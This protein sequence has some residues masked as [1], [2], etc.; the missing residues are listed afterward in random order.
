[1]KLVEGFD[2]N[3]RYVLVAARR[4]RQLQN[5]AQPV[6]QSSF[7]E[8]LPHRRRRDPGRQG[9]VDCARTA[10]DP[11]GSGY[12][13]AGRRDW[14]RSRRLTTDSKFATR[15]WLDGTEVLGLSS[16]RS[17]LI[18]HPGV[19]A[20]PPVAPSR[21]FHFVI[22]SAARDLLFLRLFNAVS[23]KFS[24]CLIPPEPPV[25]GSPIPASA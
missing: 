13:S 2:S 22:T 9:E 23:L 10:E 24:S 1:M 19:R 7:Q 16:P 18:V 3:Y 21:P 20:R 17:A 4:A 15:N 5:G 6:V 8:A 14:W 11:V 12:R 25:A